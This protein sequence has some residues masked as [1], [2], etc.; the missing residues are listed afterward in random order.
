MNPSPSKKTLEAA[1]I[2]NHSGVLSSRALASGRVSV[3]GDSVVV[4]AG[5]E[6]FVGSDIRRE[7]EKTA[8]EERRSNLRQKQN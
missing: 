7:A 6:C 1:D 2:R 3:P 4:D 8:S 5:K